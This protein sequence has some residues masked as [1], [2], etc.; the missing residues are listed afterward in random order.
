MPFAARVILNG[1]EY[2]ATAAQGEDTGFAK[3]GRFKYAE[4]WGA[5]L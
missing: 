1:R 2:A 3:E 5:H 4:N